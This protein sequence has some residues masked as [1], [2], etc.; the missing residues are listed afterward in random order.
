M[1]YTFR[2][3]CIKN[4]KYITEEYPMIFD[5][6]NRNIVILD[7]QNGYG[8]TTVFDAIEILLTGR[9][10]HFHTNLQNRTTET[11]ETL[12]ND[13]TRDIDISAVLS[14]E[15]NHEI[16]IER[17]LLCSE[18]F[19]SILLLNKTEINQDVLYDKLHYSL[20]MF[21]I[22]TYISQ[23]ESLDFLQNKYKD[24]KEYVSSLLDNSEINEKIKTLK[25]IQTK[26]VERC[27]QDKITLTKARDEAQDIVSKLENK[28]NITS[29]NTD[30]PGE[31]I[32]LFFDA[33]YPFDVI[34]IDE[35]STYDSIMTPL[36]QLKNF[37]HN[38][39]EYINCLNNAII[40]ELLN[41]PKQ[42][43]MALFYSKDI[44]FMK[45]NEETLNFLNQCKLLLG[46]FNEKKW[47]INESVF[48]KTGVDKEYS[49][50]IR[51]LLLAQQKEQ[52]HMAN[53][54]KVLA[55]MVKTR[56]VFISQFEQ[57]V[58]AGGF[59]NCKCPLCGTEFDDINK[60]ISET[61]EFIKSIHT[62]AIEIL[63]NLEVEIEGLYE[64]EVIPCLKSFFENN[65]RLSVIKD[66]LNSCKSLSTDRLTFLLD[67]IGIKNFATVNEEIFDINEFVQEY[68][69]ILKTLQ[70][71]EIPNS[72]VLKEEE[73][74]LYKS[75]HST[76]YHN[77][78]PCHTLEQLSSKTQYVTKLINDKFSLQLS[79]ARKTLE[80]HED[81]L[82]HY[83]SKSGNLLESIKLL[84][85]KYDAVNKEYQTQLANAIKIP[86]LIYSGR[87]IQNYPLGLGIRAVVNT[88][89]LVFEATAKN[90]KDV[91]NILSTGQLNGLSIAF[92][93]S[94]RNVYGQPEGL[95]ILL[96]DDPLQTIDDISAISLA[97]LLTQLE[98]GQ[99]VLSTHEDAKAALLR[100]KFERAGMTVREQDMQ[101]KY[102]ES[103]FSNKQ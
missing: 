29:L 8:K 61:E 99:I 46:E 60:A 63:N 3:I 73:I 42:T 74:D 49:N 23:S 41:I 50:K 94:V 85:S 45:K 83:V 13:N 84:C 1:G 38:Y 102:M 39:D 82:K 88:N 58:S 69:S 28:V 43:Y 53:A 54:D 57:A 92:L 31:N 78:R 10:K 2:S 62:D 70:D 68:E 16:L 77:Q 20:N 18:N 40:K 55:Q 66:A 47:S 100:Y 93:L 44:I 21:D 24:R 59:N 26:L 81:R 89:Q 25:E 67:K 15:N 80:K 32:R 33:E 36:N 30:L 11:L 86:L 12:A 27:E 22:G 6:C 75:I 37:I 17:K 91:Y 72:I 103:V 96:I 35:S 19:R 52:S 95:D 98:I 90:G 51:E 4:F 14:D 34:K 48:A 79:V 5:F 97:D 65:T 76:Y 9:I 71:K 64:R 87:I 56:T 7:G 101:E